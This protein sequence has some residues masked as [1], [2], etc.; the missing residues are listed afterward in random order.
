VGVRLWQAI[1]GNKASNQARV[2]PAGAQARF[3]AAV[4]A[5]A[6]TTT[7]IHQVGGARPGRV[8]RVGQATTILRSRPLVP[9]VLSFVPVAVSR[10]G[11]SL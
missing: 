3:I 4:P 2:Q 11:R 10:R 1:T 7:T 9:T 5:T 6:A 8:G